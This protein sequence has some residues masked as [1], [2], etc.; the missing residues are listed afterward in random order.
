MSLLKSG[1]LLP[2]PS[3]IDPNADAAFEIN[4]IVRNEIPAN[5]LRGQFLKFLISVLCKT[6]PLSMGLTLETSGPAAT[7]RGPLG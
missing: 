3:Y 5:R 1:S 6:S 2:S 7:R 4:P